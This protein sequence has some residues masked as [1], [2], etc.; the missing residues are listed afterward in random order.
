MAVNPTPSIDMGWEFDK[1]GNLKII[2]VNC[3]LVGEKFRPSLLKFKKILREK[4]E[5]TRN[6]SYVTDDNMDTWQS[7]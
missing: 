2:V 6:L 4:N 1:K 3:K 5:N 7:V